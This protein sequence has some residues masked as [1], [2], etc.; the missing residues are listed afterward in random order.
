M[1]WFAIVWALLCVGPEAS[2]SELH[3]EK[4]AVYPTAGVAFR[5]PEGWLEQLKDKG[6][7]V[8]WWI[9]PDSKPGKPTAMIMIECG[10]TPAASLDEVARG[11]AQNFR[12]AVDD[13]PASLGGTRASR[14]IAT[15][16]SQ[17]L[18]PVE[19]VA[20]IHDGRLYLA[21][22]ERHARACHLRYDR[23]RG[24]GEARRAED[25]NVHPLGPRETR[26][27][28]RCLAQLHDTARRAG[29][30]QHLHPPRGT[31]RR[32]GSARRPGGTARVERNQPCW[33]GPIGT[34]YSLIG[35]VGG[36]TGVG[37]VSD[38]HSAA[39]DDEVQL[40][41]TEGQVVALGGG[42][43]S[44]EPENSLLDEFALSLVPKKAP[45]ICF[46][47]TASADSAAY[48]VKFYRAFSGRAIPTDLTIFDQTSLPRQPADTSQIASFL[49]EQDII[50]Q[51]DCRRA[52][53][54]L[55]CRRRRGAAL[56]RHEA[57]RGRELATNGRRLSSR[58][59]RRTRPGDANG[60]KILGGY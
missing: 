59:C 18:R 8:A 23:G 4:L 21:D 44:M 14:I 13:H 26:R 38:R 5:E 49:A 20:T 55:C 7:T 9:S 16:E 43:F 56:S 29:G 37:L 39:L 2:G 42:G 54:R 40:E 34:Q 52:D 53:R 1:T 45:R 28:S 32:F 36:R 27:S 50:S 22:S 30:P 10:Q 33:R 46:L 51:S 15:N 11:L 48:I 12:G 17:A 57:G 6:K 60:S 3:Q 58:T 19:A 47:P 41:A 35:S 25:K 24:A 31:D